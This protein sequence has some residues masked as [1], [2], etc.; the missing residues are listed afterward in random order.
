MIYN[1]R[2][3]M[4]TWLVVIPIHSLTHATEPMLRLPAGAVN[5]SNGCMQNA[6][7]IYRFTVANHSPQQT[8]SP[9]TTGF[10]QQYGQNNPWN[11]HKVTE[12]FWISE[13]VYPVILLNTEVGCGYLGIWTAFHPHSSRI[14]GLVAFACESLVKVSPWTATIIH[15]SYWPNLAQGTFQVQS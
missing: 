5:A 11:T 4:Q 12:W 2:C 9:T 8:E 10:R 7:H 15:I 14:L 3:Y 6:F 13:H 1:Y